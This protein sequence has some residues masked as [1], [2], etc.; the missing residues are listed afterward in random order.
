M[1]GHV[2]N[3]AHPWLYWNNLTRLRIWSQF[4]VA[5]RVP[6]DYTIDTDYQ[7]NNHRNCRIRIK[8]EIQP[9]L[10]RYGLHLFPIRWLERTDDSPF[11]RTL[12]F[13]W[14]S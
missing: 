2:L 11:T 3:V 10:L 9:T 1:D 5:I 13:T 14:G 12:E 4:Q 8:V 6:R 7:L